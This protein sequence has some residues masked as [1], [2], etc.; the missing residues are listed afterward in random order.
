[1]IK[2]PGR[3]LENTV[4]QRKLRLEVLGLL[5]KSY[6]AFSAPEIKRSGA[7]TPLLPP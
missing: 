4:I 1:M 6:G 7:A 3:P 5:K 2:L